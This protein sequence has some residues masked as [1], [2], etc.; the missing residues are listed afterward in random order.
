MCVRKDLKFPCGKCY[1]CLQK[2]RNDWAIRL[3]YEIKK[4]D[5]R[6]NYFMTLT[7]A[8]NFVPV[9]HSVM[10]LS[11]RDVELFIKR[12][13]F[14]VAPNKF[15]FF[16]CGE[17]CP[18]TNRPHYHLILFGFPERKFRKAVR[19]FNKAWGKGQVRKP[20]RLVKGQ[21]VYA[22][23]YLISDEF[24]PQGA[25]KPFNKMSKGLGSNMVDEL[26]PYL[27]DKDYI[28]GY[29]KAV[30]SSYA[31]VVDDY[32]YTKFGGEYDVKMALVDVPLDIILDFGSLVQDFCRHETDRGIY[33]F[34]IPKYIRQKLFILEVRELLNLY[35]EYQ[36]HQ[37]FLKYL[38]E[39]GEYDLQNVDNPMWKQQAKLKEELKKEKLN[40]KF[41][42]KRNYLQ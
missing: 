30:W 8:P 10:T 39:Y 31:K 36:R 7:Y 12:L 21:C 40:K 35:S 34:K 5:P 42:D 20:W 9:I 18:T 23:K 6:T 28:I 27:Y 14:Y 38:D 29:A 3:H 19:L 32:R 41:K 22:T 26:N 37:D 24:V 16:L 11:K 25:L 4:Y 1:E 15:K 33:K 13:R 17:Y 2:R